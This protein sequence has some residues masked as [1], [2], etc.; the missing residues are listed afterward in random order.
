[1]S[2][3]K[4]GV[5]SNEVSGICKIKKIGVKANKP[6][7]CEAYLYDSTKLRPRK[8][9]N[10]ISFGYK[11][12]QEAKK[13]RKAELKEL[14]EALKRENG[15]IRSTKSAPEYGLVRQTPPKDSNFKVP[16][17]DSKHPL[18]GDLSRFMTTANKKEN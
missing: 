10:V 1:M 12:Q 14:K 4:C 16:S 17:G 2:K 7:T 13:K 11:A 8:E 3:V 5:C 18:T 6:R 9:T 15:A